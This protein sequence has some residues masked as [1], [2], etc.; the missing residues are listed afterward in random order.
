MMN[1]I[2][3]ENA[4]FAYPGRAPVLDIAE[5][6][7]QRGEK[8]FLHG[9]SGSGKTTLLGLI[10]GI[11][12]PTSGRIRVLDKDLAKLS[13]GARDEF[14]GRH[15]GYIFQM[16]NL[17]PYLT[18]GENIF[19]PTRLLKKSEPVKHIRHRA[20][21]L[22]N[23]LG[24]AAKFD[25]PVTHLSVGQ[26]QRVAAARALMNQPE[27]L[28]ADEPTSSLD[29][30]QRENFIKLLFDVCADT[31]VVFVSHDPSLMSLFGRHVSLKSMNRVGT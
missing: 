31:T 1:G 9:P 25:D 30:D 2:D 8:I 13:A 18:V 12:T 17:I 21:E 4:T 26:Q 7:I 24:I 29:A 27:I 10:G 19:L 16:F 15:L 20:L 22:A 5:L 3:I 28:V 6:K 23:R 11:L 14:R